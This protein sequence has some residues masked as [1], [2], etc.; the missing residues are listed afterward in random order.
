MAGYMKDLGNGKFQFE[1]SKGKDGSGKRNKAYKTVT[2]TASTPEAILKKAEKQL[3]LF[4]AE[5]EKG[6]YKKPTNYTFTSY[7]EEWRKNAQRNLAP[8]TYHR[9]N[10]LLNLHIIPNIGAHKLEEIDPIILENLYNDLREP[11]KRERTLKSGKKKTIQYSLSESTLKHIHRLIGTV[12]QTAFRKGLIKEN[13]IARTDAPKVKKHEAKAYDN[14]SIASLIEALEDADIQF[15]AA[16]HITLAAGCRLG[17]LMGLEWTDVDFDNNTITIRQASQYIPGQ[18]TFTKDPKNDT[19]KRTIS[20]PTPVMSII[21]DL[22]HWQKVRK[23]ELGNKWKGCSFKDDEKEEYVPGR[24]FIQ[25][26]GSP[27]HPYTPSKLWKAFVEEK[28]LPK[29]TFHG[30][31]HT[32]ASY[33]I[34]CGQDVV[35][36]AKRLGHSNSN[37]TLSIYAHAFKKRD[38]EAARHMEGLYAKKE[39]PGVKAN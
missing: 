39:K 32:S 13:P 24:L 35:S 27:M 3:A 12:L 7:I 21:S 17:E 20:M 1:V 18:G 2:I 6:E 11:Q 5:V 16:V 28:G 36:V 9:Y 30:L 38:E 10:E 19:S 34:A 23:V 8:K 37:T 14:E 22:E 4:V 29:L 31:R 25:A 33:L 15:K 26:D